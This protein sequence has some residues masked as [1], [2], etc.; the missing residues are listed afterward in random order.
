MQHRPRTK[1]ELRCFC[2]RQPLLAMYGVTRENKIYIHVKIY[3]NKR[4]FGEILVTEGTVHL[5]CRE[6][7]RWQ[8]VVIVEPGTARLR[9]ESRP[10]ALHHD[11]PPAP[12]LPPSEP[13]S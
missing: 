11:P 5:R 2:A 4:T 9:P 3:K 12:P 7:F 13:S 8:R 10:Q 1:H 6:C